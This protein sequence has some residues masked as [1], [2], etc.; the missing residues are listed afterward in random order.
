MTFILGI[1]ALALV[2][3]AVWWVRQNRL[4][5]QRREAL[6]ISRESRDRVWAEAQA[7]QQKR[8]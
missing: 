2:I 8:E 7:R 4:R 1:A 3:G 6:R 5:A